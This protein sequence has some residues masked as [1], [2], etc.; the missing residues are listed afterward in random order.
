MQKVH[1]IACGRC[2][3]IHPRG[4]CPIPP[5]PRKQYYNSGERGPIRIFR[6]SIVWQNKAKEIK[7]RDKYL[8]RMCLD[9]GRINNKNLSV[10][11]IIPISEAED[12]KLDNDNLIT[13]CWEHHQLVEGNEGYRGYLA[14]LAGSPPGLKAEK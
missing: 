12:R 11:H 9:E 6:S 7:H 13:L 8:C 5:A 10:H 14:T 3:R 2:G 4:Q 1:L